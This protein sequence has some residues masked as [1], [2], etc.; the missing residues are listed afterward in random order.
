TVYFASDNELWKSDGTETGTALVF[1]ID[2]PIM[3][4]ATAGNLV[5]IVTSSPLSDDRKLW[6][7]D[8]T[9]AGTFA[10]NTNF[11]N[12]NGVTEIENF[13]DFNGDLYFSANEGINGTELWKSNGTIAGTVM[14]KD[15]TPG[16]NGSYLS[17][18]TPFSGKLFFSYSDGLES[19]IW[20]T[21]GT[22]SGTS[23]FKK[24]TNG[25]GEF[26]VVNETLY[27]T[28]SEAGTGTEL[29]KSDGTSGGTSMIK[30]IYPGPEGSG[31]LH[32]RGSGNLLFF[33]ADNGSVGYELWKSD[34][35]TGGTTLVKDIY[36]GQGRCG[37]TAT[38]MNG[39]GGGLSFE[40]SEILNN[41]YY[42]VATNGIN[43]TELWT[44]DGTATGTKMVI[45]ISKPT[46]GSDPTG[47]TR[48][49]N[50]VFFNAYDPYASPGTSFANEP[51]R[52]DG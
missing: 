13:C 32:L 15:I 44:S 45:D 1:D 36:T 38:P 34:G 21:D 31:P 33:L 10:I 6:R 30:D 20:S 39:A 25:A 46:P 35:T 40:R 23:E 49:G 16:S 29:W 52:T 18:L 42:F 50:E 7:S 12:V 17:S 24:F 2:E 14:V 26:T 19:A 4:L 8:G 41:N 51:F 3:R 48:I 47:L 43:G 27:F 37:F 5:Y 22:E 11:K 28:A 9:D